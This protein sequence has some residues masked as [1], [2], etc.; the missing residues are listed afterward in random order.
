MF[1][2]ILAIIFII[3]IAVISIKNSSQKENSYSPPTYFEQPTSSNCHPKISA[4]VS[5]EFFDTVKKYCQ[6]HSMTV[7]A[8]IRM[9]VESYI[10]SDPTTYNNV[11]SYSK[12]ST[13]K[14]GDSWKCPKCGSINAS[15]FGSCSCGQN[16]EY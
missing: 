15:Y 16:K 10:N 11:L 3:V 1:I 6:S 7:S 4:E 12:T 5:T 2:F 9:A 14:S 8:L 13:I